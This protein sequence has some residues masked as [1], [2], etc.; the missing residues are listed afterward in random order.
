MRTV[1]RTLGALL[2]LFG[3]A[4]VPPVVCALFTS[5][6]TERIF[7]ATF[8]AST[9]AGAILFLANNAARRELTPRDG[10]LLVT[11]AY[12]TVTGIAALPFLLA[13]DG[14][15]FTDAYFEAMSGISATGATVLSGLDRLP[16]TINFWRHELQWIGGMGII[17]LAVAVMPLLGV[18]GMQLVRAETPGPMKDTKLTPRIAQTAKGLW[19]LYC[20]LTL[21][22]LFALKL[23][24]MEWFDAVC[25]AFSVV[26]LGGFSTHDASIGHF[27]S[28]LIE[29]ILIVFMIA[30][31]INFGTHFLALS[32]RSFRFYRRDAELYWFIVVLGASIAAVFVTL[33]LAAAT[34]EGQTAFRHVVFNVVS[35]A[36][37]TGYAST[38]YGKWPLFATL[39]MLFLCSIS[40]CSG[41]AGGGIKMIR[42][43][44]LFRQSVR[45]L[46][47]LLH[48]RAVIPVK[49]AGDVVPNKVV[50][51]ILAFVFLYWA[52][53][54]ILMLVFVATG[55]DAVSALGAAMSSINNLGPGLGSV[56]P[57]EN[58]GAFSDFQSWVYTFGMLLG[59]L[60][61]FTILVLLTPRF[62]RY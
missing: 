8:A 59:R 12:L 35:V 61:V 38:D 46:D 30:S 25:H 56:G 21:A 33:L 40:T 3:V 57:A 11:L 49:F 28:P 36:T 39:I 50:F 48:P 15:S 53:S 60:E 52:C 31:A 1:A 2:M 45:E 54:V 34:S 37:T 55:L 16:P 27:D 62:W 44:L 18:G 7:I 9:L 22:A 6:G 14:I 58:Y 4:L 51:S 23:A 26:S 17:V 24:G 19:A 47:V 29:A 42:A 20:G 13:I 10:Y 43:I 32:Q 41:S 5:D